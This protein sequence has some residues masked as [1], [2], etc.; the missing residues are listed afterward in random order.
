M[1]AGCARS[2]RAIVVEPIPTRA[3]PEV[4]DLD[5]EPTLRSGLP[6]LSS[7]R[8]ASLSDAMFG[9]AMTLLATTLVPYVEQLTGSALEMMRS[10]SGPLI[11]VALSFAISAI[12]WI[13]QQ[14]RLSM[15][16][17]L[18]PWQ[19]LLHLVFL[20]LIV[21]LPISTGLF[22]RQGTD[23]AQ[24]I[25]YGSH[26]TLISAANLALWV[27]VHRRVDVRLAVI[28]SALALVLIG[29]G[30]VV[31]VFRP[32]LAQYVWYA[33]FAIRPLTH[34]ADQAIKRVWR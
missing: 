22:A 26:L 16:Q 6:P 29:A 34:L 30:L 14:S 28:P 15:T 17:L 2:L 12:Y 25:I 1:G 20:F 8:L 33:A 5:T 4:P 7:D 13:S 19:T 24:V 3:N 32:G 31:G 21:L 27:E 9:V 18:T 10:L 23:S 11:A